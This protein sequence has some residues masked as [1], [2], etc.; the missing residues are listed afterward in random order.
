MKFNLRH[1]LA[2]LLLIAVSIGFGFGFDAVATVIEK[3]NHP[4]P[5]ALAAS[6]KQNAQE[7]GLPEAVVWATVKNG[8]DF[9]SNAVS[10]DG[11]IGL[12]QI[13]PE[14]FTFICTELW[15]TEAKDTGLLYDPDTNLRAGCAWL[16]YL[17][18]R[19]GIWDHVFAAYREGTQ[20]VDAWLR[21]PEKL[22][23]QGLLIGIPKQ[24][25]ANYVKDTAEAMQTYNNLYYAN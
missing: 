20:T 11:R 5:E 15:E 21:D 4:R 16:S 17:Y 1:V 25:T 18:N 12:M 2:F 6:V 9:A 24:A 3:S 23:Q 22:S 19:Y 10:E 13:S 7:F 8:S 14:Q